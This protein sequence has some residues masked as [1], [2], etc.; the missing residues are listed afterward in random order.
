M[1]RRRG[2]KQILLAA[3]LLGG[4]VASGNELVKHDGSSG[5]WV[6]G[7]AIEAFVAT[8]P[9][10][11]VLSIRQV[12]EESIIAGSQVS[13]QGLRVGFME[14]NQ[15]KEAFAVGDQ[16]ADVV[17]QSETRVKVRLRPAGGLQYTV[18]IDA[19]P[20]APRL[21][22]TYE[23]ANI[24]DA[25]RPLACWSVISY[26][27]EGSMIVPLG[28]KPRPRKRLLIPWWTSLPQPSIHA[29]REALRVDAG[30]ELDGPVK[31]GVVTE[32]GWVAFVRNQTALVS[33]APFDPGATYPE[34]GASITLF[35]MGP[36]DTG[37]SETE[38]VGVLQQI[39]P[40]D[41]ARLV[42]TIDLI[43]LPNPLPAAPDA[44]RQ[45]LEP[46]LALP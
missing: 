33:R 22:L 40:G 45:T 43:T 1:M 35:Q 26:T 41:A 16:P 12:G 15:P 20:S 38:Q 29:G 4:G 10:F 36:T 28:D 6:R 7:N 44:A 21:R 27:R 25:A 24:G 9:R 8:E 14:A 3:A 17:E 18:A 5:V 46:L 13:D 23:L 19:D 2:F 30:G 31:I 39:A 42:E 11:R 32:C 37:R 34:D